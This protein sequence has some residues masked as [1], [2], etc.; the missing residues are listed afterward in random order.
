MFTQTD[1][2]R[3]FNLKRCGHYTVG[4]Y[5]IDLQLFVLSII[6]IPEVLIVGNGNE[7]R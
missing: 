3:N 5:F 1:I 6:R 7:S 2:K 4:Q